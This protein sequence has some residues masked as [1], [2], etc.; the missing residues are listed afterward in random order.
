MFWLHFGVKRS[1]VKVT[2]GNVPRTYVK[3]QWREFHQILVTDTFRF[4]DVLIR[5]W[6]QKIKGQGHTRRRHNHRR[7][8]VEF[9]LVLPQSVTETQILRFWKQTAV[10]M[11]FRFW[12]YYRQRYVILHQ[13]TKLH[14]KRTNLHSIVTPY[15]FSRCQLRRRKTTSG[16]R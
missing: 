13:P 8:P 15:W 7:L 3:N 14:W 2:A 6:G 1:K 5:F 11:Q 16:F 10:I 4:V 12:P 9:H